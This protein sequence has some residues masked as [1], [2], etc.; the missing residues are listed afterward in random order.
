MGIPFGRWLR[1]HFTMFVL[2]LLLVIGEGIALAL[3]LVVDP[4]LR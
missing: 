3:A 4:V 2:L 1:M